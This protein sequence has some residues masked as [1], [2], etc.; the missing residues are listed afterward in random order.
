M[1]YERQTQNKLIFNFNQT[2]RGDFTRP[3]KEC[4]RSNAL[5]AAEKP[6]F[7]SSQKPTDP[8]TAKLASLNAVHTEQKSLNQTSVF[9][10]RTHGH[11]GQMDLQ[12]EGKPQLAFSKNKPN[13][14]TKLLRFHA[15]LHVST[16]A[17]FCI[18]V[19]FLF[20]TSFWSVFLAKNKYTHNNQSIFLH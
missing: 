8:F 15:Y 9:T 13:A 19:L 12:A 16:Y 6:Q 10:R 1:Q 2:N 20:K 7:L 18:V 17:C 3:K 4:L 5:N 11:G 14:K